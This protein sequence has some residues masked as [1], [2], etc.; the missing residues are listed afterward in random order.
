MR[1]TWKSP[2]VFLLGL[3]VLGVAGMTVAH[4]VL[5]KRAPKTG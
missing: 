4:V 1:L 5:R 3:T 2:P